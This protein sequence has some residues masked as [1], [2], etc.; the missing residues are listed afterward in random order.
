MNPAA[1]H[2]TLNVFPPVLAITAL[3]VFAGALFARSVGALRVALAIMIAAALLAIPTFLT[4]EPAEEMVEDLDGV[5][6]V[7]IHPHEEAGE[8]AL[9]ALSV[10]GVASIAG[11]VLL[12]K[13]PLSRWML[14]VL[15]L[16]H[17]LAVVAVFRTASLGGKIRHPEIQMQR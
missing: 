11:L 6:K 5:N 12:T 9:I 15:L 10:A 14:L 3:F 8:F 4:G 16:V 1:A 2:L 17:A 13:R 7:S